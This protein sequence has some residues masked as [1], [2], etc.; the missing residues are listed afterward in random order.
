[1]GIAVPGYAEDGLIVRT[2]ALKQ[3]PSF[4]SKTLLDLSPGTAV[5]SGKRNGGWQQVTVLP[6]AKQQG[7]VRAYQVRTDLDAGQKP[8]VQQKESGGVMSG[9]SNLS[10]R[11]A[12]LFGQRETNT[13][14]SLTATIGVRGL[15][16]EDL[17]KAK[18]NPAEL[19]KMHGFSSD[20][21]NASQYASAAGLKKQTIEHLPT[22]AKGKK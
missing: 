6:Q 8:V 22:P 14:D 9:L 5:R 16:E 15:N 12:G 21:G 13:S 11:T 17:N 10:R 7:W 19:E 18:P 1:M 4:V 3:N 2:S 20:T